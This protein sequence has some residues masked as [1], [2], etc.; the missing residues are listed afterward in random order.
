MQAN[1]SAGLVGAGTRPVQQPHSRSRQRPDWVERAGVLGGVAHLLNF[2]GSDTLSA[3]YY[4]QVLHAAQLACCPQG[5]LP[6]APPA[7]WGWPHRQDVLLQLC[8]AEPWWH[9][10]KPEARSLETESWCPRSSSSMTG[11]LWAAASLPQSTA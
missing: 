4:A 9:P 11:S 8:A 6:A 5:L 3:C 7:A 10:Q 1:C 2:E